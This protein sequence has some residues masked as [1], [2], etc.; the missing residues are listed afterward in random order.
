MRRAPHSNSLGDMLVLV[1]ILPPFSTLTPK[2]LIL[3]VLALMNVALPWI[4]NTP[5][6]YWVR[7][8][9]RLP[10]LIWWAP[11][12]T[13]TNSPPLRIVTLG[14]LDWLVLLLV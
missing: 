9:A 13:R 11:L 5:I 6:G 12:P 14:R 2:R 1:T 10:L 8:E 3:M 7:G 4:V